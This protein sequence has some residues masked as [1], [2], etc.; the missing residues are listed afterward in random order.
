MQETTRVDLNKWFFTVA[1]YLKNIHMFY[2]L[3]QKTREISLARH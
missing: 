1:D 2:F 3:R